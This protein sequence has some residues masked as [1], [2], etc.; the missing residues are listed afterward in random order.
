MLVGCLHNIQGEDVT[1][2]GV[3]IDKFSGCFKNSSQIIKPLELLKRFIEAYSNVGDVVPDLFCGC[4]TV[5]V[6]A[7]DK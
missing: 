2:Q 7:Q 6:A 3:A 1:H 4:A 5:L